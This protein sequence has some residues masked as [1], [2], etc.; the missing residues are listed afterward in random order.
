MAGEGMLKTVMKGRMLDERRRRDEGVL[1]WNERT[2]RNE[3]RNRA[4]KRESKLC[5]THSFHLNL[6]PSSKQ[7]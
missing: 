6:S 7:F 4:G 2:S 5:R 1:E 3:E